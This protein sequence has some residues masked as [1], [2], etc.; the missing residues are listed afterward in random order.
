MVG[1]ITEQENSGLRPDF[2]DLCY[3]TPTASLSSAIDE[4]HLKQIEA[5]F[6]SR[7]ILYLRRATRSRG[8]AKPSAY[9][10]FRRRHFAR[11]LRGVTRRCTC[12]VSALRMD[13]ALAHAA[14]PIDDVCK[15]VRRKEHGDI[16]GR[17][18][19]DRSDLDAISLSRRRKC[20]SHR[21]GG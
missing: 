18:F 19:A 5:L 13:R 11:R 10:G 21:R 3:T 7:A 17:S 6:R 12:A 1:G 2:N 8:E 15:T 4:E 20:A 9:A 16:V 14:L